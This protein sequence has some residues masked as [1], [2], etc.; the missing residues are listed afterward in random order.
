MR[1]GLLGVVLAAVLAGALGVELP[2]DLRVAVCV[3]GQLGRVETA[4]KLENLVRANQ[5]NGVAVEVYMVLQP[6][7]VRF[8]NRA[9]DA[10][11]TAAP[12]SLSAAELVFNGTTPTY[13]SPYRFVQ[14]GINSDAWGY[15]G[16][17]RDRTD[18]LTNQINQ[19]LGWAQCAKAVAKQE[20]KEGRQYDA[21]LRMRDNSL[22]LKPFDLRTQLARTAEAASKESGGEKPRLLTRQEL[23]QL[24]VVVKRCAG[25][26]G[27]ND[28]TMLV[29]RAHLNSA[30][31][32][33]ADEF[34]LVERNTRREVKNP[35]EYLKHVMDKRGVPVRREQYPSHFPLVD[36]RCEDGRRF[37]VVANRKD[38]RP[39][40]L[41]GLVECEWAYNR[42]ARNLKNPAYLRSIR[43]A[44]VSSVR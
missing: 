19:L 39:T 29:P 32:G 28:K 43:T 1:G 25:W 14:Y 41:K 15:P 35:E 34:F 6:G 8:T 37:C 3:V 21:V 16:S 38:C 5:A 24:P 2:E 42:G 26:G 18:R 27:Y 33:P 20:L 30:M 13:V 10:E 23:W 36:G 22:V 31:R 44:D 40:G 17:R 7:A 12:A 11:C 4:T 9:A